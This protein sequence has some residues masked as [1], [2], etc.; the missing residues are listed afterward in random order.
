[1]SIV[2][3]G[4]RMRTY[5]ISPMALKFVLL[6]IIRHVVT[7]RWWA[8]GSNTCT[9]TTYA[10]TCA[11]TCSGFSK[12]GSKLIIVYIIIISILTQAS[13]KVPAVW[14]GCEEVFL[15]QGGGLYYTH[16]HSFV[17]RGYYSIDCTHTHTHTHHQMDSPE[18]CSE[19]FELV[20]HAD[21]MAHLP[22][23]PVCW[24]SRLLT[25]YS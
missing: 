14:I 6:I 20:L 17:L 10:Y 22:T 7:Q 8:V 25:F 9:H 12:F 3:I 18:G 2:E 5:V 11:H 19:S 23:D 13:K 16:I 21:Q 24:R 15:S 4:K 1:M